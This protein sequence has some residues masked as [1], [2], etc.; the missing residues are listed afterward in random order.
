[1]TYKRKV[2]L[3]LKGAISI[4]G[5]VIRFAVKDEN[6]YINF[7]NIKPSIDT[8]ILKPNKDI[9]DI[10]IYIHCWNVDL[11]HE[12]CSL[13]NPVKYKFEKNAP[14][15]EPYHKLGD[16]R[17]RQVSQGFAIKHGIE[18][19]ESNGKSYDQIIIYRPDMFLWKEMNLEKYDLSKIYVNEMKYTPKLS[20]DF[21]FVMNQK[22][23]SIF[24][25]LVDSVDLG[26]DPYPHVWIR[27]YVNKFMGMELVSDGILE[28][29]HQEVYRKI[30]KTKRPQ[31]EKFLTEDILKKM[32]LSMNHL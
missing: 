21:H 12:L 19:I 24:K 29:E 2:A 3:L 18:L 4:T 20:G 23:A 16:H 15:L 6:N 27:K 31:K 32:N 26:N 17:M 13:Y 14:L 1:M 9:A 10:D 30:V 22:N 5:G 11:Q 8:F 28:E 7:K 25:N